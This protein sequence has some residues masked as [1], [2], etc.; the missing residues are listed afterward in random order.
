VPVA[1]ELQLHMWSQFCERVV[2]IAQTCTL[3][4]DDAHAA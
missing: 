4:V 3:D 2:R 1:R